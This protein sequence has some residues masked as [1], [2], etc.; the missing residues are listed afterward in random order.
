MNIVIDSARF[1]ACGF[2]Q[3][4]ALGSGVA[5]SKLKVFA[6]RRHHWAFVLVLL[7]PIGWLLFALLFGI[8]TTGRPVLLP[9]STESLVRQHRNR[10]RS[11]AAEVALTT[12]A[13]VALVGAYRVGAAV[14]EL[15]GLS[16]ACLTLAYVLV[17]RQLM[18]EQPRAS[19]VRGGAM[20]LSG[21]SP[22][23][24]SACRSNPSDEAQG[25][26][27]PNWRC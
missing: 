4:D 10:R 18:F 11:I 21:V 1:T 16:L 23:F 2:P 8:A 13:G 5:D 24:V 3:V 6:F 9:V 19:I 26:L 25:E 22:A 20:R 14:N 27:S 15:V 17:T 12:V 7:G